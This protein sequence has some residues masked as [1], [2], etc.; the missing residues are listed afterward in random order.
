MDAT[1]ATLDADLLVNIAAKSG[2]ARA[3]PPMLLVNQ[4]WQAALGAGG[5]VL[6]K[7]L[8]LA[9]F[10]RLQSLVA[11]VPSTLPFKTLYRKQLAAHPPHPP[12][13]HPHPP[14]SDYVLSFELRHKEWACSWTTTLRLTR[15]DDSLVTFGGLADGVNPEPWTGAQRPE[16]C[17][18]LDALEENY[19]NDAV[20][21][22]AIQR[23]VLG[24]LELSIFVTR[25]KDMST[26]LLYSSV[27]HG[28]EYDDQ[29]IHFDADGI[30][31]SP[32]P[33]ESELFYPQGHYEYAPTAV[34]EPGVDLANGNVSVGL[35]VRGYDSFEPFRD[36]QWRMYLAS[37]VPWP[38]VGH[39]SR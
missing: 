32:M 10:P 9:R 18:E 38:V 1:W 2:C 27:G 15:G 20:N 16:W 11:L 34:M 6:W 7:E 13:V 8:A 22:L 26:I 29:Y 19:G 28:F 17:Q 33:I 37:V 3:L 36:D 23:T 5:D 39:G 12:V 25:R 4:H 31:Q 24:A 35:Y 14:L 21:W 30:P